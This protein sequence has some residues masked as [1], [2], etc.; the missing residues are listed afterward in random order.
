MSEK[1]NKYRH[2]FKYV[3]SAAQIP[4]LRNQIRPFMRPDPHAGP[5]GIYNIRSLYFDDQ[6]NGCFLENE[7]GTDPREKFRIRIYNHS[8]ERISLECKRKEHGKT[9][10]TSCLLT[11]EQ[12]LRLMN[13]EVLAEDEIV[14]SP[15]LRKFTLQMKMRR[16]HP[17][18]IV[19]YDRIPYI[20]KNGNVRVTF[21]TNICGSAATETFLD[22]SIAKRPIMPA[23]QHLMEVKFDEFLPDFIY[24]SLNPCGFRQTTFSKFYLCRKFTM[25]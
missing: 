4:Y 17:V 14:S 25:I 20:Y 3:I 10:K 9:L 15:L 22:A 24:N 7:N 23:G 18:T 11:A 12:T 5:D 16:L 8:S 13:G 19:E 1:E 2:E 21:D 6:F